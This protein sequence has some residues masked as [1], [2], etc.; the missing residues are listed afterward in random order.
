MDLGPDSTFSDENSFQ[1][2]G[3]L[4]HFYRHFI[5]DTC[6]SKTAGDG[7]SRDEGTPVTSDVNV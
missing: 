3:S 2:I 5:L 1:F 6:G 4:F 7:V